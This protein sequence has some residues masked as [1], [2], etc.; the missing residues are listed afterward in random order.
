MAA[1]LDDRPLVAGVNENWDDINTYEQVQRPGSD[2]SPITMRTM[3]HLP[4]I[5][6]DTSRPER[7]DCPVLIP[8]TFSMVRDRLIAQ[9]LYSYGTTITCATFHR[10]MHTA[11]AVSRRQQIFNATSCNTMHAGGRSGFARCPAVRS[12]RTTRKV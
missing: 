6:F 2:I 11:S 4:Q 5:F 9:D 7:P 12:P 8:N 3:H 10:T 1:F